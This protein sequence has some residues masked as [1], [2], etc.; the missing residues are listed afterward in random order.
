MLRFG[1]Q[2][3]LLAMA[4]L[5]L[6][7]AHGWFLKVPKLE[8]LLE[9]K[10]DKD[11]AKL[12]WF[13]GKKQK[14]LLKKL[15]I[16]NLFTEKEEDKLEKKTD[17]W[18]KFK[19]WWDEKKEKELSFF[20][21][22]KEKELSL[23]ETKLSKKTGKKSKP[24]KKTTVKPCYGYHDETNAGYYSEEEQEVVTEGEYEES[25]EVTAKPYRKSY[26]RKSYDKPTYSMPTFY[27]MRDASAEGVRYFT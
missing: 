14:E 5:A 27:D 10:E 25:E 2:L 13:D 22:K 16:L 4:C 12:D 6:Q 11:E 23:F 3:M 24:K 21:A 18:E 19:Q 20:E 1:Q 8:T 15:D 9:A 26:E 17:E 7:T